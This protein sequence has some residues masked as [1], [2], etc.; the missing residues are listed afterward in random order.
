MA[1]PVSYTHLDVY[2]RQVQGAGAVAWL[3]LVGR[4]DS[5]L[6]LPRMPT[7]LYRR[8]TFPLSPLSFSS[9]HFLRLFFFSYCLSAI[10][11]H[12]FL[13]ACYQATRTA[14]TQSCVTNENRSM[15]SS[16][17]LS[18]HPFYINTYYTH[19]RPLLYVYVF[20]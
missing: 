9:T 6:M 12:S 17:N 3:T 2:K 18:S 10:V 4:S 16:L 13:L 1:I 14:A 11:Y 8:L 15:G 5:Q 19:N 20:T 7:P